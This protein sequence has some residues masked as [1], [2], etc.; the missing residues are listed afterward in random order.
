MASIVL[1]KPSGGQMTIQPEDGTSSE[2]VT[3]PSGGISGGKVLNVEHYT[4]NINYYSASSSW[5]AHWTETYTPIS[6]TSTIHVILSLNILAEGNNTHDIALDWRGAD[7]QTHLGFNK[8]SSISGW[9]QFNAS[10]TYSA[11]SGSTSAGDLR[12]LFRGNGSN[13]SYINY[14]YGNGNATSTLTIMEVEN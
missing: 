6:S 14:N 4:N 9:T 8:A 10:V 12:V 11:P 1:N 2:V 13:T 5:Y 3:I 7:N